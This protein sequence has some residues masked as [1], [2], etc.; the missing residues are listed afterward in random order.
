MNLHIYTASEIKAAR[1]ALRLTQGEFWEALHVTQ[2][3]GSR[4]ESGRDVPEPVQ[5]LLN[6]VL[7]P[8]K[9][10]AAQLKELRAT[11]APKEGAAVRVPPE[12]GVLP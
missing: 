10:V 12:F 4:Y 11:L 7:G 2:S 8:E 1:K 9:M 6:L 3:G 5:V